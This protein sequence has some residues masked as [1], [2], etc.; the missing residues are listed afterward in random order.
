M[1]LLLAEDDPLT[2][3]ALVE[4]FSTEGF[5]VTAV[6]DGRK[7][8]EA[9]DRAKPDLVCLDIMMPGASGYE[10]C[11]HIRSIDPRVPLLFV[12]AK[13]E[14]IDTVL[15]L[16]LGADDFIVKPFGTAAILARIRAV[17]R[18]ARPAPAPREQTHFRIGDL[19]V[20]PDELRARRGR[21]EIDLVPRD[22]KILRL[23]LDRQGRVV[24]R[25]TLLDICWGLDFFPNSRALDQHISQLRKKVERDAAD[26]RIILTVHGIGYRHDG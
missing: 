10:V 25:N 19:D 15:G 16:E 24:D 20:F 1:K 21:Q 3:R 12:S 11:R 14:E 26:P 23:L 9:F 22:I 5:D 8:I 2:R 13:S 4:I 7:A 17:L 18:R 6:E